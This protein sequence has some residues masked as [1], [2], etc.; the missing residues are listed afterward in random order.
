VPS[1]I[2][3]RAFSLW[4]AG[5]AVLASTPAAAETWKTYHNDRFGTTIEYPDRFRSGRPPDNGDG[6]A[7]TSADGAAFSV[8]GGLNVLEYD[9]AALKDAAM[10]DREA[11]EAI[12]Y[13]AQGSNWFVVSGTRGDKIFYERHLI[14]HRGG[15]T[16][17]FVMSY[18]ASLKRAYDPIVTRMS[19]SFRAGRGL[20]AEGRP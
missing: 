19:K 8:F 1:T 15:I 17:G 12:D 16:N 2:S 13:Q 5:G 20:Q 6:L 10:S 14:S 9:L 3:R 4:F 11:G 7:F 18:P